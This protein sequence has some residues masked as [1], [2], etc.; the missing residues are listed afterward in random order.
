MVNRD[1][2]SGLQILIV[3]MLVRNNQSLILV[4]IDMQNNTNKLELI[5]Q[6]VSI[7]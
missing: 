2:W 1:V 7:I 4:I 3:Q 5:Q 6:T